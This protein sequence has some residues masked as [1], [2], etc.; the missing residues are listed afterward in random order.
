M[1]LPGPRTTT[2]ALAQATVVVLLAA[3]G[4]LGVG[5]GPAAADGDASW[6]LST[7]AGDFGSGRQNY[8]YT[9][10]PGGRLEDGLV[11]V[12]HGTAPLHLAV[13]AADGFTKGGRLDLV[14]KDAKSTRVGAWV[15]T[16][17]PDVTVRP[18]ESLEVPFTVTLPD[19]AAP[20]EYMGGIVTQAGEAGGID[21]GRR[22]GIRIR[23]RVGGSLKPSLSAEN[24][25]V[26]YSGT[27][28]PFGKGDATVTYMI[29]NTGNA[30]LT[31]RQAVSISGP[32]GRLRVGTGQID[33]SPQLLPGDTWKVSV[34]VHGV[35]PALRLTGTVT[36]TPLLTD[37]AGSVAP[38]AGVE[39]TTHAWTTPW[40]LLIFLVVLCGLVVAGLTSRRRR[41]QSKLREDARVQE[42]DEQARISQSAPPGAGATRTTHGR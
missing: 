25:H 14:T 30:I 33:D 5:A 1:H 31:A 24:L 42:A 35:T 37:A 6:A 12:N 7:A 23:L 10:N 18:G 36:L 32:F 21:A 8:W 40:A 22:L 13:Y 9:L 38:L 19:N 16:D 20:G 26:R 34:P 41:R 2:A 28:N 4:F 27:P 17:R 11:V 39:T 29:H 15:H 3:L